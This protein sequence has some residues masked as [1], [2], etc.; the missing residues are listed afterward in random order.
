[1][2]KKFKLIFISLLSAVIALFCISCAGAPGGFYPSEDG[3]NYDGPQVAEIVENPFLS[4]AEHPESFFAAKTNPATYAILRYII[5]N[6]IKPL[7]KN[8]ARIEDMVNYFKYDFPAPQGNNPLSL[9]AYLTACPWNEGSKLLTVALK[10]NDIDALNIK[11]NIVMLVD[12]S[13]SMSPSNRLPLAIECFKMLTERFGQD[14]RVS[15]VTYA[16]GVKTVLDGAKGSEHTKI[17][18]ALNSLSSGGSTAGAG[19]IQRA[20]ELAEKH[21]ITGGNNRIILATDGDF[22]VGVSSPS[23]LGELVAEKRQTGIFSRVWASAIQT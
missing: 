19:G 15:V 23:A 4:V 5:K 7:N 20:Y 17:D 3:E 2:S 18:N 12:V 13:G 6:K 22:N 9:N 1:M 21:F 8:L 14:D 16:G 11:N 10:A